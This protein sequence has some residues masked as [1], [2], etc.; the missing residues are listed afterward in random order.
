MCQR[1]GSEGSRVRATGD[2]QAYRARAK[3]EVQSS[4]GYNRAEQGAPLQDR[5]ASTIMR[6]RS[7]RRP[8]ATAHRYGQSRH[9]RMVPHQGQGS[10]ATVR[11]QLAL[12]RYRPEPDSIKVDY[13]RALI[14]S[15]SKSRASGHCK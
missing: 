10:Y 8:R 15:I 1:R 14:V 7:G 9:G 13:E 11:S 6:L 5:E 4:T 3:C 12:V 2:E